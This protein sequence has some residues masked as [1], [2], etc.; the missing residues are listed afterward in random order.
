MKVESMNPIV[1]QLSQYASDKMFA[2]MSGNYK[3]FKNAS[4]A[5]GKLA[6]ENLELLPQVKAPKASGNPLFS[7][8]GRSIMKVLFLDKF[9]RKTPEEKAV[10]EYTKKTKISRR[11][12]QIYENGLK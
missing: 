11:S 5:F 12:T 10:I 4:K 7:K 6:S 3:E 8:I 1:R 2:A 9:R